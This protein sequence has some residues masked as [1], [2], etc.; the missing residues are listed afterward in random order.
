MLAALATKK[1]SNEL[2]SQLGMPS[3]NSDFL[4]AIVSSYG[5]LPLNKCMFLCNAPASGKK[6]RKKKELYFMF[7][8]LEYIVD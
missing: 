6:K 4:V 5:F 2:F 1:L 7:Y 8:S 3:T